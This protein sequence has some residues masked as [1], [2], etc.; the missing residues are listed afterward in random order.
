M[1]TIND[2]MNDNMNQDHFNLIN[3]MNNLDAESVINQYNELNEY[4]DTENSQHEILTDKLLNQL[5]SQAKNTF[6]SF[7]QLIKKI[8]TNREISHAEQKQVIQYKQKESESD[9]DF[10]SDH[11]IRFASENVKIQINSDKD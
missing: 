9:H 6:T 1:K 8:Y 3:M 5:K 2:I 4:D 11:T 10:I 7:I